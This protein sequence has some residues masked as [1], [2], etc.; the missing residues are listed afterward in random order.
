MLKDLLKGVSMGTGMGVGQ[1]LT[2]VLIQGVRDRFGKNDLG[3][4]DAVNAAAI[5][6]T[7]ERD[8]QCGGCGAIN[9]GDSKFC[10]ACGFS[11]MSQITLASGVKCNCGFLNAQ[12]QQFC[13][14]CGKKL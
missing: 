3:S 14:E 5:G 13:S 2:G 10:G 9:T 1:E 11:L 4:G 6:G 7:V 12:G 8:I